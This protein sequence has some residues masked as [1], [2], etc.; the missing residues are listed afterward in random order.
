MLC[1]FVVND[2]QDTV[3]KMG[4]LFPEGKARDAP[5]VKF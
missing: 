4:L 2:R 3:H 5:N 1:V